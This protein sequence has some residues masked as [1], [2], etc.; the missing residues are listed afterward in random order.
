LLLLAVFIYLK[1]WILIVVVTF[2]SFFVTFLSRGCG[3]QQHLGL[4]PGVPDWRIS[5]HTVIFGPLMSYLYWRM[6]YHIEHHMYAA[7][8]FFNLRR[9]HEAIDFD[10]PKSLRGFLKGIKRILRIQKRQRKDPG[11]T[12]LPEFPPAAAAPRLVPG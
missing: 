12:Y 7:V 2:G 4:R 5:C 3:I 11:Y 6:N 10:T 1:L 9:L 8:P